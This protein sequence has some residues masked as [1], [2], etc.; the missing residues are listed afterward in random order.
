MSGTLKIHI[1]ETL[2]TILT[3]LRARGHVAWIV[4]GAVRDALLGK[5]SKD[6]DIEV[7]GTTLDQLAAVLSDF[8]RVDMVGQSFGVI[9]LRDVGGSDYDFSVPRRDSRIGK[10]HRDFSVTFDPSITP[11]RP[12][13]CPSP[14][15]SCAGWVRRA[16]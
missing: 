10:W 3:R 13:A 7:Y 8:G 2:T 5:P 12:P 9:K 6:V 1:S 11:T 15:S 14:S 4:G 16:S